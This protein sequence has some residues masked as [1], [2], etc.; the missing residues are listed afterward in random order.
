MQL[1]EMQTKDPLPAQEMQ[2]WV[3][4]HS[5][6]IHKATA[7]L[8]HEK[9]RTWKRWLHWHSSLAPA[10]TSEN[11]P[12][13]EWYI[14]RFSYFYHTKNS[15]SPVSPK[16]RWLWHSSC[17]ST[18]HHINLHSTPPSLA[19]PQLCVAATSMLLMLLDMASAFIE[20]LK[21]N[22]LGAQGPSV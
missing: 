3:A 15:T 12:K 9:R 2:R 10:M 14:L 5:D 8:H 6:A 1:K 21:A 7:Q 13:K 22:N 11:T 19:Q 18:L 17:R 4:S 20:L 16:T